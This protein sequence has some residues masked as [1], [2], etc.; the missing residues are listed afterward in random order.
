MWHKAGRLAVID[1]ELDVQPSCAFSD[2]EMYET[3]EGNEFP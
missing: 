2:I 3:F 1:G